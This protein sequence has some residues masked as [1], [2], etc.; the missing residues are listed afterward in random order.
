M[1]S[2]MTRRG[3]A[4]RIRRLERR[5]GLSDTPWHSEGEQDG[6][7]TMLY[8]QL[9]VLLGEPGSTVPGR[10]LPSPICVLKDARLVRWLHQV[11]P[12]RLRELKQAHAAGEPVPPWREA[13]TRTIK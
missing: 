12:E 3:I 2:G 13:S 8:E 7:P 1:T 9:L 5:L 6:W 10:T 11:H 4:N